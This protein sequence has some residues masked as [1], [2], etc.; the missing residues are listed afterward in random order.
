[1][2][3][4]RIFLRLTHIFSG[5]IWVG[6]ALFI[7]LFLEPVVRA[8]GAEGGRV[9]SR[10]V[11][12]TAFAKYMITASLLTVVSGIVLYGLDAGFNSAWVTSREGLIFSLG[13]LAGLTAYVTGLFV[14]APTSQRIGALGQEMALAGGPPTTVQLSEMTVL[15]GRALR[16]GRLE[17][18]LMVITVLGMAGARI[19]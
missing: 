15:Q 11:T 9:M 2:E 8:A 16:F 1:M 19:F 14:I 18:F 10:L 3:T 5:T 4:L 6:S 13:S 12:T 17:V 7:T